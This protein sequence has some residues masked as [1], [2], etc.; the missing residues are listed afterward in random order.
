MP[1]MALGIFGVLI[2]VAAWVVFGTY[3]RIE[4]V[5]GMLVTVQ[6]STKVYAPVAGMVVELAVREG[7][8]VRKGD[9]IAVINLDR[10]SSAGGGHVSNILGIIDRRKDVGTEQDALSGER[11]SSELAR[12][13]STVDAARDREAILLS[14]I[15]LQREVVA[16]TG[17]IFA[18]LDSVVDRGFVSKLEF[19]RRRQL[20][21]GARQALGQIEDQLLQTRAEARQA[22]AQMRSLRIDSARER[23]E[24]KSVTE[25]LDQQHAQV[26][27]EGGYVVTAPIDGRVTA[28]QV[29]QGRMASPQAPMMTIV[30][31]EAVFNA[32]VYAPTRAVGFVEPGQEVRLLYDAFPYERF[33]SWTG[34]VVSVSRTIIDPRETDIPMKFEEPVYRITVSVRDQTLPAYGGNVSLQ[35]GMTL[36][37]NI[38]LDRQS[39]LDW[40]LAPLR[41]VRNREK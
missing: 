37:A 2:A 3:S 22:M 25:M 35:A 32:E 36:K 26:E 24:I 38:V 31:T 14:Q 13:Q 18:Q 33:G 10:Q 39:F 30:P 21:I 8:L 23:A 9:R 15:A 28:L 40:L 1:L 20:H 5:P 7:T 29:A 17:R 19:E 16:S 34:H 27:A 6:P 4:T 41:A 11:L 12:M